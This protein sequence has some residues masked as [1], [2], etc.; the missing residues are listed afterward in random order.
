[1][2][3]NLNFASDDPFK[4]PLLVEPAAAAEHSWETYRQ[5]QVF[6]RT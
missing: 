6:T 4:D 1:M 2:A 3:I 5:T